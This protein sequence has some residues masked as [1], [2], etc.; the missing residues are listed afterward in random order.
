M[1][2]T[3]PARI[4]DAQ[5]TVT[6]ADH[7]VLTAAHR[8]TTTP[9]DTRRYPA[10]ALVS[11][12]HQRWEHESAYCPPRHTTM[13]GRVLRSGDRAGVEQERWSLLTLCQLLRTA[14]VDAAESRPGT[15]PDRCGFAIAGLV[16]PAP[17]G[18]LL[19]DRQ[20]LG[21]G[22]DMAALHGHVLNPVRVPK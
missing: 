6:C 8:L 13:D 4:I 16:R 7:T 19:D 5:I 12:Y 20:V 17:L 10:A 14:M 11:L 1:I 3:N 2:G 18:R 15:D 9:S 21:I 22:V